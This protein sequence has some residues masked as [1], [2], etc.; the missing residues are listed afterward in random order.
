MK[1]HLIKH[2]FKSILHRT[3]TRND[4]RRSSSGQYSSNTS[5]QN[6]RPSRKSEEGCSS[7]YQQSSSSNNRSNG[8]NYDDVDIEIMSSDE[9]DEFVNVK[10]NR[11]IIIE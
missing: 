7:T 1:T 3:S 6:T 11:Y 5:Q 2:L 8:D 10:S 9:E 4:A